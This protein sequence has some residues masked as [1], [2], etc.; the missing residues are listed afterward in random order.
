MRRLRVLLPAVLLLALSACSAD[1]SQQAKLATTTYTAATKVAASVIKTGT[2]K[3]DVVACIK[4][5]DTIAFNYE[6]QLNLTAQ[7]WVDAGTS[8]ERSTLEKAFTQIQTAS[9]AATG[10]LTQI[11]TKGSCL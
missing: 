9:N 10:T 6:D 5:A 1:L 8:A 2:L 4:A 3:P 11:L 7:K